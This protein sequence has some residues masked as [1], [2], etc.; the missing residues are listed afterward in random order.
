MLEVKNISKSFSSV[1]AIKDLSFNLIPSKIIGLIGTNGSGKTTTFR[2]ILNLIES[3][4]GEILWNGEIIN[5]INTDEI[6]YLPE[7]RGLD[8]EMT[9]EEHIIYLAQLKNKTKNETLGLI[10][11]WMDALQVKGSKKDKVKILSKGN[12]QKIQLLATLIHKPKLVILDEPFSGLDPVNSHLLKQKILELK[13]DSETNIIFSSHNMDHV[14]ELCDQ[15]IL[16]DK[17]KVLLN[18]DLKLIKE[19]FGRKTLIITDN[20]A[21][22]NVLENNKDRIIKVTE[23]D[24]ETLKVTLKDEEVGEKIFF[25]VSN[26]QYITTFC[27]GY[28]TLDEI[29]RKV[30]NRDE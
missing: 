24:S 5:N 7:E 26:N 9:V 6:G 21:V 10:D 30:V 18:D 27:Q 1:T 4:N 14:E 28:P 11:E 20:K 12:Q 19:N 29:F 22:R 2:M 17:G 3:N 25:E 23:Y 16:I 8:G 15:L 13:N